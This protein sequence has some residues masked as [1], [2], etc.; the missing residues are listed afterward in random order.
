MVNEND[1]TESLDFEISEDSTT[2]CCPKK[3]NKI[4]RKYDKEE[5]ED[6]ELDFDDEIDKDYNCT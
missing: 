5:F 3:Q 6:R 1:N 2:A 4:K